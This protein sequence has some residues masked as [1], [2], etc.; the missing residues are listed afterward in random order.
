MWAIHLLQSIVGLT[1]IIGIFYYCLS[2]RDHPERLAPAL[3][4]DRGDNK[5]VLYTAAITWFIAATTSINGIIATPLAHLLISVFGH[6]PEDIW[7]IKI[8]FSAIIAL[9]SLNLLGIL[10]D[11]A[12][13]KVRLARIERNYFEIEKVMTAYP[14]SNGV[15]KITTRKLSKHRVMTNY[16]SSIWPRLAPLC[17]RSLIS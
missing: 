6:A 15:S 16:I 9:A 8:T 12:Y 7:S 5:V 1:F 2:V 3:G 11:Y 10:G 4:N 14:H 13:A 17:R